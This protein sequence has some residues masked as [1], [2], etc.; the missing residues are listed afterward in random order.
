M[1]LDLSATEEEEGVHFSPL[2]L[3][4]ISKDVIHWKEEASAPVVGCITFE[5][6]DDAIK[7]ANGTAYG[8]SATAFTCDL[9]RGLAVA[10][11][12]HSG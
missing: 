9:R 4:S 7:I 5:S 10:K 11:R 2:V 1:I 6:E 3:N 12:I 8:L